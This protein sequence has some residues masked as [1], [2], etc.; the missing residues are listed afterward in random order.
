MKL[1]LSLK[2]YGFEG[3]AKRVEH[4]YNMANYLRD[5]LKENSDRY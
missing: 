1:W 3:Y 5:R 4:T 2:R